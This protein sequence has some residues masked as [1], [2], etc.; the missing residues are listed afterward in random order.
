[1]PD[2]G[3][4][5][6]DTRPQSGLGIA[7]FVVGLIGFLFGWIPLAGFL[8]TIGA[9][10]A[11]VG[12]SQKG[13]RHGLAIAG[14]VLGLLATGAAV[15]W[16]VL[17]AT[18]PRVSCPHIYAWDGA[19]YVLDADPLSGSIFR[20]GESE[21]LDRLEHLALRDGR[22][23]L[24]VANELDELDHLDAL[25]LLVVD[26]P[27]ESVVVPSASG[28]LL[29]VTRAAPPQRAVDGRGR[30][31]R[32]LLRAADG[33][34]SAGS[35]E[36]HPD[37]AAVDPRRTLLLDF[38]R[39]AGERAALLLRAHNTRFAA[40][41]F[42]DY[43]G[44]M[45]PGL[46]TLL[47][48]AEGS[49]RYPYRQRLEDEM[50][51]LGLTLEVRSWLGGRWSAPREVRPIGP[52]VQRSFAVPIGLPPG[53]SAT[54]RIRIDHAPLLWELDQALL[55]EGAPPPAPVVLRP[56]L[57]ELA[58]AD[59]E[60]LTLRRG[61]QLELELGAPPPPAAGLTRSVVLS[62]R[63]YYEFAIPGRG[64]L[65]PFAV[66]R[67]RSARDSL[68]RFALRLARERAR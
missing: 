53:A 47:H 59:G 62:I 24:R 45:G 36:D 38:P 34:A 48:L 46:G 13:K 15:F 65:D 40:E 17:L 2:P 50:R 19:R 51:R 6:F 33:R 18:K 67:H 8:G 9:V 26:H 64:L 11:I 21:D 60:R 22:Y 4:P 25:S 7:G 10:L 42:V 56:A 5:R 28:G 44:A 12:L 31:L 68:P 23:R 35:A 1:M 57:P 27:R 41:A 14:L 16:T 20:A 66:W 55:G 52:A 43:L 58:A 54:V 30:D 37:S 3:A 29:A 39:P 32:D 63:G 49:S 61:E